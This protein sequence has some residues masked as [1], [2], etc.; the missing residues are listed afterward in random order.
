MKRHFFGFHFR[1]ESIDAVY[2]LRIGDPGGQQP[3]M[4][5]TKVQTDTL[6]T[7]ELTAVVA[8]ALSSQSAGFTEGWD[9]QCPIIHDKSGSRH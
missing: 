2:C 5:D 7:H 9:R 4:I 1:D 8:G 3:V 6:F